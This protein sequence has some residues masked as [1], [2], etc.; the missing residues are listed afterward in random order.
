MKLSE[1]DEAKIIELIETCKKYQGEYL[2][3]HHGPG[4]W[5]TSYSN[6]FIDAAAELCNIF[7]KSGIRWPVIYLSKYLSE[8][9]I[10]SCRGQK[11]SIEKAEYLYNTH[12]KPKID[13][14]K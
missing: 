9:G 8:A 13:E 7:I 5:A 3:A 6:Q 4:S 11:M 10:R 12:L 2:D 1:K 14:M